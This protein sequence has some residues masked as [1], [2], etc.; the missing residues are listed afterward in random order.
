MFQ[1]FRKYRM[2]TKHEVQESMQI[3]APLVFSLLQYKQ[4]IFT[5][6]HENIACL[7]YQCKLCSRTFLTFCKA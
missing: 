1:G 6:N 4:N 3:N 7:L 5:H 2:F